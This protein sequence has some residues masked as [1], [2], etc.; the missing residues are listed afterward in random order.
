MC[1]RYGRRLTKRTGQQRG[2]RL[3]TICAVTLTLIG[4]AYLYSATYVLPDPETGYAPLFGI[5]RYFVLQALWFV[6]GIAAYRV[7]SR[8]DLTS[9]PFHW[10]GIYAPVIAMLV[11]TLFIGFVAGGSR[12]WIDLGFIRMQPSEYAKLGYALV[13][14]HLFSQGS[15]LNW[16]RFW[17]ALGLLG[18]AAI[19]IFLQPDLGTA[20]VF[21]AILSLQLYVAKNGRRFLVVFL[22][23]MAFVALIGWNFVLHDYQK[24]RIVGFVNPSE[25]HTLDRDW[26]A[27]QASIA[28]GSGGVF[29]KGFRQGTQT[30][31]GFVP[32]DHTDFIF[33]VVGE[34][35]G[36]LG[37][38]IVVALFMGL[39]LRLIWVA[40]IAGTPYQ[41]LIAYGVCAIVFFQAAVNIGMNAGAMP[42]AGIPLPFLSYGGNSLLMLYIA[43]GICQSI[44]RNRTRA[45]V[46]IG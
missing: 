27:T 44:V 23:L 33:T 35:A 9:P 28:I 22:L 37:C 13:T 20:M 6:L 25:E 45:V 8:A 3:L 42:I 46:N 2:D 14:A 5:S 16:D 18:G 24:E 19:L 11:L 15:G 40:E 10:L 31:G 39:I 30:H 36:F 38:T 21:A 1:P 12:R 41:R 43:L 4:L 34:E 7:I 17:V 29:G 26:Q 32:S